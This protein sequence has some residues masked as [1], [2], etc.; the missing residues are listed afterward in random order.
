MLLVLALSLLVA[1]PAESQ[2]A[3]CYVFE[4][5]PY[6]RN[7]GGGKY[8]V[9]PKFFVDGCENTIVGM[10]QGVRSNNGSWYYSNFRYGKYD[11]GIWYGRSWSVNCNYYSHPGIVVSASRIN[12]GAINV[13]PSTG[14]LC[15]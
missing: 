15:R 12:Y 8:T 4:Y 13:G 2:A 14:S 1:V 5:R 3:G 6:V 9:W 7:N 10:G 11:D